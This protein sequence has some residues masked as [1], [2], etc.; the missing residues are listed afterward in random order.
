VAREPFP[1]AEFA[2]AAAARSRGR[3]TI[4]DCT[5]TNLPAGIAQIGPIS[6]YW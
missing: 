4:A 2:H 1:G 6:S 5:G 3:G